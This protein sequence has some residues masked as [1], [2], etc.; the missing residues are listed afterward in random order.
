MIQGA[1][2]HSGLISIRSSHFGAHWDQRGENL[3][4]IYNLAMYKNLGIRYNGSIG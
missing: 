3:T 2:K 4:I 1:Q